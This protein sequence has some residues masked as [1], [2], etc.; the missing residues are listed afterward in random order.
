VQR[1]I[2]RI[3]LRADRTLLARAELTRTLK[4]SRLKSPDGEDVI[5]ALI[6]V[7]QAS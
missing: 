2:A 1:A 4:E 6:R 5:D 7:L 3:L